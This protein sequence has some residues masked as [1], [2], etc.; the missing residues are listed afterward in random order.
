[1]IFVTVLERKRS[2]ARRKATTTQQISTRVDMLNPLRRE[3]CDVILLDDA[4]KVIPFFMEQ[5]HL[6]RGIAFPSHL[7]EAR[8]SVK[9]FPMRPAFAVS[10]SMIF[11]DQASNR[12][13]FSAASALRAAWGFQ[14]WRLQAKTTYSP[15]PLS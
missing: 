5:P 4:Q 10:T 15:F 13:A 2:R 6:L 8:H 12:S 9:T 1:M 3:D 11:I 14:A 7:L